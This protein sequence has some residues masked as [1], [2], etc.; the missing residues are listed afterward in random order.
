MGEALM[1]SITVA[2]YSARPRFQ[3]PTWFGVRFVGFLGLASLLLT[4][5]GA[6]AGQ[7]EPS[8]PENVTMEPVRVTARPTDEG[9]IEVE[10]YDARDL[11]RRGNASMSDGRCAEALEAYDRMVEEFPDSSL[12][13]AA[14]YNAAL[15]HERS[16]RLEEAAARYM[17][18]V[19]QNP[20]SPDVKDSLFQAAR[21]RER[22]EQWPEAIAVLDR[23]LERSDLRADEQVEA[24]S[25]RG[26]ALVR[27][28]DAAEGERQLRRAIAFYRR[29]GGEAFRTDYYL[30]QAQYF[31]GEVPR[32]GMREITLSND[33]RVFRVALEGRCELLLRAQTQ[34]TQ[35]IRVGNAHWAAASAY[36]I[37]DMYSSLYREIMAIPVPD[38][39][40]PRDITDPADIQ[41]FREEYPR[42][43]RRILREYLQP[44][45]H[46]AIR[47]WESNLMM[48]ERTGIQGEWVERTREDL[49]RVQDL[50]D[51]LAEEEAAEE[52]ESQEDPGEG[53]TP[54]TSTDE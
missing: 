20:D 29:Q 30:A 12:I 39:E 15:C 32:A 33:E 38:A 14:H 23:L 4:G 11:L 21:C 43:Y 6:S 28:G 22:L 36:R 53:D 47:W 26:A 19:A 41:V 42:H 52:A 5:C 9:E 35:A 46:H 27:Q 40:V 45:L 8:T 24:M 31:L 49:E 13:T 10:A 3:T 25:R 54:V 2:E 51:R 17:V 48:I 50:L 44:L 18:L 37:G 7:G 16:G 34:Y 1:K